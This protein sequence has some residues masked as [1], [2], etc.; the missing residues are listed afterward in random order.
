M[1]SLYI[2]GNG[3]DLYHNMKTSYFDFKDYLKRNNAYIYNF[4]DKN[5]KCNDLWAD[6][7]NTLMKLP[8]K[9]IVSRK[10]KADISFVVFQE[11]LKYCLYEWIFGI[12]YPANKKKL[13]ELNEDALF[14]TFNY[15]MFL[16]NIYHISP[17][18]ILHIHGMVD[19]P[20][21]NNNLIFGYREEMFKK[22]FSEYMSGNVKYNVLDG[23]ID[24]AALKYDNIKKMNASLFKDCNAII[25][26]HTL[27]FNKLQN[28]DKITIIGHS[29]S[30]NDLIYFNHIAE[31]VNK[32]ADYNI[33]Y[34]GEENYRLILK[35]AK[36]FVGY[37]N[38]KYTNLK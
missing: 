21:S 13:Y 38:V 20:K 18:K 29:L 35:Q 30:D 33:T 32:K 24:K 14:I 11:G 8:Y 23:Y 16:E 26:K 6:L 1:G 7:E 25:K 15:T 27:F 31:K 5:M 17:K 36:K 10:N 4:I 12:K 37:N 28:V 9:K 19:N 22:W 34:Y 3:F 2:L